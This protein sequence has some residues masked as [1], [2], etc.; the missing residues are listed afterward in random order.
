MLIE[1]EPPTPDDAAADSP[2]SD[3]P[4]PEEAAIRLDR[5][6]VDFTA[7]RERI[8]S[9]KEYAIRLVQG[10]IRY[11]MFHALRD[12]SLEVRQGEVF[13]VIGHNGAGK[14]TLLKVISRVLKP[15]TGR[16]VVRGAIAPLL[17]LGAGF[18]S[19]LTGRENIFLNG[20][21][22]GYSQTDL[23]EMFDEIVDFAELWDFIEAPLRT[24]STG[25]SVRLGFAVATATRPDVLLVD[26]VLSVGDQAFQDKCAARI[27]QFRQDGATILL[28]THNTWLV[29]DMCDRAVWLHHGEVGCL[30]SPE[31]A[32]EA[33]QKESTRGP[34]SKRSHNLS[35]DLRQREQNATGAEAGTGATTSPEIS[36][37]ER[38]AMQRTWLYPYQLPGGNQTPCI[39]PPE[40]AVIHES[41]WDMLRAALEQ[42]FDLRSPEE[43]ESLSCLDLGC[44]QGY[45]SIKLAQAGCRTVLG[46]DARAV[47][48]QDADLMRRIYGL[49]YLKFR[50]ADFMGLDPATAGQ[51]DIVLLFALLYQLENPIGALRAAKALAKKMVVVETQV[52]HDHTGRMNWG[53]ASAYK[54]IEGT[55][56]LLDRSDGVEAFHGGLTGIALCPGRDTL[57]RA[58]ELI[59]FSRVEVLSPPA[60]AYDLLASGQRVVVIGH[61]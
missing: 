23:E 14:S 52:A 13:G 55:F 42:A 9:F 2:S 27:A 7:P 16:V 37:L 54:E 6:G 18:H 56:A 22:L 8:T 1:S 40:I 35:T 31:E 41:R 59:G 47:N 20:T 24:Y 57:V 32:V 17:E 34:T 46:I 45:Y 30:G 26:E 11:D 61:V 28:V 49:R 38:I 51:F 3:R 60:G 12:V 39:L 33:Y 21:L 43:W 48:L 36:E 4:L 53:T 25:M 58:M 19:E 44:G 50:H 10:R 15:T 5:V 29:T